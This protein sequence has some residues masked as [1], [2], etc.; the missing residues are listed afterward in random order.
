MF[1]ASGRSHST[2]CNAKRRRWIDQGMPPPVEDAKA[3]AVRQ[4]PPVW[5]PMEEDEGRPGAQRRKAEE[6]EEGKT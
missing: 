4:K 3:E 5:I 6:V 1:G 2:A